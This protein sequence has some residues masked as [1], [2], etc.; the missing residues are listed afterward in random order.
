MWRVPNCDAII[1][2]SENKS[3]REPALKVLLM[4]KKRT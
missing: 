2:A 3:Q 4:T 1:Q